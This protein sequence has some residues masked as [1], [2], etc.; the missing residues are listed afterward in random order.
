MWWID[1][2]W[3]NCSVPGTLRHRLLYPSR[4]DL[5]E[6][7]LRSIILAL[8]Q[9]SDSRTPYS[10]WWPE[11]ETLLNCRSLH[12]DSLGR[13]PALDKSQQDYL[14]ARLWGRKGC[15]S[16]P[17]PCLTIPHWWGVWI[18]AP[19]VS[20][21]TVFSSLKICCFCSQDICCHLSAKTFTT[22]L[23]SH[24]SLLRIN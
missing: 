13:A 19:H 8:I 22:C 5:W 7:N 6:F 10:W 23:G 21:I 16:W 1:L 14:G 9:R 17:W 2:L 18:P 3:I 12:Q 4:T 15:Q 11:T 20:K 24:M